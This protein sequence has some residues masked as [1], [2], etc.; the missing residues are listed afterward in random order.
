MSNRMHLYI[1]RLWLVTHDLDSTL[2]DENLN[3]A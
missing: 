2:S 1:I 3:P